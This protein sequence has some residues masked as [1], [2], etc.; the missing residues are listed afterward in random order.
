MAISTSITV[1]Q[2]LTEVNNADFPHAQGGDIIW[3][4]GGKPGSDMG[5]R[6]RHD[7]SAWV[8]DPADMLT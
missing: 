8:S 4:P 5:H 1:A 3:W 2:A 6:F 7:G